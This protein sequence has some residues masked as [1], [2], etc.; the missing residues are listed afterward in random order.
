MI[1][2]NRINIENV[3]GIEKNSFTFDG[4]CSNKIN[5]FV[6]PNGTGKTSISTAFKA[7]MHGRL[8]LTKYEYYKGDKDRK[9]RLE[10]EYTKDGNTYKCFSDS[11]KGEVSSD[12]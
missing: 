8:K 11:N 9:P 5:L 10:L 1:T 6:A 4:L 7:A 12:F 3:K 2:I